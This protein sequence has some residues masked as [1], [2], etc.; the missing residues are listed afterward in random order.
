MERVEPQY[1]PL[2]LQAHMQGTVEVHAI[3]AKDGRIASAEIVSGNAVLAKAA[4]SAVLRWRYRPTLLNGQ[5]VEVET[6][7]RVI[8][9]LS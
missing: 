2:A 8:F 9:K 5:A 6:T 7:I 3:I 1:P 4:L